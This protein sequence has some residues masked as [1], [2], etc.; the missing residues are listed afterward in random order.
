MFQK[1]KSIWHLFRGMTN[2]PLWQ[3]LK[4]NRSQPVTTDT[5]AVPFLGF[6]LI[7]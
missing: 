3:Q 4:S 2:G 7:T 5:T 1:E 6:L